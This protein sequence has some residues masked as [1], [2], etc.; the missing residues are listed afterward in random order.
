MRREI[1]DAAVLLARSPSTAALTGAGI[2]KESGIPTF[3][4][5]GGIWEE[6]RPEEL[7]TLDGFMSNP[8]L[9]WRWY[10][11][12]LLAARDKEPNPG[13]Y[14][15]AELEKLLSRFTLVTQNIDNLH[16][17]AGNAN[18]VELHGNIERF[19][20]LERSHPAEFDPRWSDE[21]PLCRCGSIIRPDV[22]WFGEPLPEA[23]LEDAFAAAAGCSVLLV[24]GTSGLVSPASDLPLVAVRK[25]AAIIEVN[26]KETVL[27]PMT[28][29]FLEGPSGEILPELA[30]AVGRLTGGGAAEGG[31]GESG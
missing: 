20:C 15:M 3:R 19:K 16:R 25:G 24:V 27:T 28:A 7:A 10:R 14:A 12:R 23:A 22:V 29:I 26:I 8:R 21:P 17:K 30:A 18:I 11:E 13:H 9:V 4:E 31:A 1:E 2:S 5:E 6:Y